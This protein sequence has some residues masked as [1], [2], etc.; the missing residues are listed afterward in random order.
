MLW[1]WDAAQQMPVESS[2]PAADAA[3]MKAAEL[4]QQRYLIEP[5]AADNRLAYL[6]TALELAKRRK[7]M[8]DR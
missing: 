6:V 4:A 5:A 1:T 3:F 8:T 7:A 2:V